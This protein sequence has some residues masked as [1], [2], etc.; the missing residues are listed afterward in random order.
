MIEAVVTG[1]VVE[2]A[3]MEEE[4]E[5]AVMEVEE[6]EAAT[7]VEVEV[8]VVTAGVVVAVGVEAIAHRHLHHLHPLTLVGD[9]NK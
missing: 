4:E 9:H 3:A 8:A 1:V 7:E 2:G 5:E 6:E